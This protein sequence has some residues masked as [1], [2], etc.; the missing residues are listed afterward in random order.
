MLDLG[1]EPMAAPLNVALIGAGLMGSFHAE[2]LARRLPTARLVTIADPFEEAA[3]RILARLELDDV[4]YVADYQAVLAEP[5]IQAVVI[6]S[7]GA[8]HPEVITAAAQA[9]K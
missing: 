5:E 4:R 6:A 9:G 7:P 2:T 3:R 8:T 1:G